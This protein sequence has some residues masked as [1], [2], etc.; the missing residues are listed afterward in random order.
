M[1]LI[2]VPVYGDVYI[3]QFFTHIYPRIKDKG[4]FY[5][6]TDRQ[7][8]FKGIPNIITGKVPLDD[9]EYGNFI[10]G[11]RLGWEQ[12]EIG[13]TVFFFCG[14]MFVSE[15]A[16]EFCEEKLK[17]HKAVITSGLRITEIPPQGTPEELIDFGMKH[18]HPI[19]N[20][21]VWGKGTCSTVYNVI[22]KN[23]DS[24]VL[25]GFH[26]HPFAVTKVNKTY[27]STVDRDLLDSFDRRDLFIVQNREMAMV[28]YT[29]PERK[30]SFENTAFDI[31]TLKDFSER[32]CSELHRWFFSHKIRLQ[33]DKDCGDDEVYRRVYA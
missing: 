9:K 25:R 7:D 6:H 23:E 5:I 27:Q 19:M 12:A 22:F 29:F 2:V 28:D 13:E 26:L 18:L 11:H 33:G 8:L 17:T 3:K 1:S 32:R 4:R 10:E 31:V 24:A 16:F 21:L 20:E 15:G 30:L 14:D